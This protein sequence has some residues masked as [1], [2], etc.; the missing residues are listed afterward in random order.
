MCIRDRG[1]TAT[2][3]LQWS[4]PQTGGA[5]GSSPSAASWSR[6]WVAGASVHLSAWAARGSTPGP[7]VPGRRPGQRMCVYHSRCPP[8]SLASVASQVIHA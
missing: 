1:K 7:R 3:S 2:A 6:A 8:D 5:C 4:G